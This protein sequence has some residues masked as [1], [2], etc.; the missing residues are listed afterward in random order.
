MVRWVIAAVFLVGIV[1]LFVMYRRSPLQ[2]E[3]GVKA[4]S[5]N[6]LDLSNPSKGG[7]AEGIHCN[8]NWGKAKDNDVYFGSYQWCQN[9]STESSSWCCITTYSY[10]YPEGNT[11]VQAVL[12]EIRTTRAQNPA[13]CAPFVA[14]GDCSGPG[15]YSCSSSPPSAP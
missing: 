6:M 11:R 7:C 3:G 9:A 5:S 4:L 1:M 13:Y 12:R 15:E 2:L 10:Y 8:V 14:H